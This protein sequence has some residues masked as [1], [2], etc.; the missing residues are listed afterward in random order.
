MPSR[1]GQP[2]IKVHVFVSFIFILSFTI[3][4]R[5]HSL[6]RSGSTM[7]K[8]I[9]G[10]S[11]VYR[12]FSRSPFPARGY[13]LVEC[14]KKTV[15]DAHLATVGKISPNSVIVTS[16][17]ENFVAD[18]CRDLAVEETGLFANQQIT[19]H[20]EAIAN[21]IRDVPSASAFILP[22]LFRSVP[23]EFFMKQ[24]DKKFC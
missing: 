15:F 10:S 18:A 17:L 3:L 19:T 4:V 22:L 5:Y 6:L 2:P 11:N 12:N 20:V 7:S 16:V 24:K 13:C 21:L 8:L 9:Y 1:S 14:T 23:G